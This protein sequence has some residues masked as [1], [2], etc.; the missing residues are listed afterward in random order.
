MI[1]MASQPTPPRA[2]RSRGTA[3][4][5]SFWYDDQGKRRSRSFGR[6]SDVT[7]PEAM[8][9][10]RR[11]LAE[12]YAGI[13]AP[14]GPAVTVQHLIDRYNDHAER[15]YR[16]R[17]GKATGEAAT[18][19]GA[20]K[21][22][23]E[24]Y[25][26]LD[27]EALAGPHVKAVLVAMSSDG[28]TRQT[29]N[30]YLSRI[31]RMVKWAV[32]ES[33]V[34]ADVLIR[35]QSV[36]ALREGERGTTEAGGVDAVPEPHLTAVL[37]VLEPALASMVRL[38]LITGMRPG[39]VCR[40]RPV[41]IDVTVTPWAY[42]PARHKNQHRGQRRTVY[43]GP[44][45]RELVEPFLNRDLTRPLFVPDEVH[46]ARL[47]RRR[48][49]YEPPAAAEGDYR[50]WPSAKRRHAQR[51]GNPRYGDSYTTA[52]YT[53][54]IQSACEGAGVPLWSAG[55]LRHNAEQRIEER[56]IRDGMSPELARLAAV[57]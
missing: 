55:Q 54:A 38:Q 44:Q 26:T 43:L 52:G 53:R 36:Q 22:L 49:A 4:W 41:D 28:R 15:Y 32:S 42:R 37:A 5:R 35:V 29:V 30:A 6:C 17:D 11:F 16:D 20:L 57:P 56:F 8:M 31:R 33:L 51:A 19:A 10:Y 14:T 25:G 24:L 48:A 23:G 27:A 50:D 18:I 45:A 34:G 2:A 46:H 13:I 12:H 47:D 1:A 21:P 40:M 3:Y 9:G 39:E 7:E